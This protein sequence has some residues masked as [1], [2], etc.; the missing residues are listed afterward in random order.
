[1]KNAIATNAPI[2]PAL[3]KGK[4]IKIAEN[5]AQA[6]KLSIGGPPN[7]PTMWY[8][9]AALELPEAFEY[10]SIYDYLIS[11]CIVQVGEDTWS[12]Q[13]NLEDT[14]TSNIVDFSTAKP[15]Q[16]GRLYFESGHVRDVFVGLTEHEKY[17]CIKSTV[18]SSYKKDMYSVLVMINLSNGKVVTG[19]CNCKASSMGR[20]SHVSALLYALLSY[21]EERKNN[22][23][24]SC[25]S[26]L[27][28]WNQGR[29]KKAPEKVDERKYGKKIHQARKSCMIPPTHYK[30][31][32]MLAK[33]IF[34][35]VI[36]KWHQL[37]KNAVIGNY[38]CVQ[39]MM[40]IH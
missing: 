35:F 17:Y 20:C 1:M 10:S 28:S 12:D 6:E 23:A 40:I 4:W 37:A 30:A 29:K 27:C 32:L 11:S 36:C 26:I 34:L 3:D 31:L 14:Q 5:E 2:N 7:F 25:T 21:R 9:V 38:C 39:N 22:E 19:K 24:E 8:T 15:L 16:R 18:Q 13:E 33:F